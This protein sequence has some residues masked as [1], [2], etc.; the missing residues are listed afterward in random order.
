MSLLG[1]A[2]AN[3]AKSAEAEPLLLESC[4]GF[5]KLPRVPPKNVRRALERLV[6]LY[7]AWGKP[8]EAAMWRALLEE[9]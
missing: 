6:G 4:A 2:L 3:Q 5:R 9:P 1:A 7:E 8:D